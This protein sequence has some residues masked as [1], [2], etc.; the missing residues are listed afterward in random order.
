MTALEH[1]SRRAQDPKLLAKSDEWRTPPR[2]FAWANARYGPF[3]LDAAAA[4][5]NHQLP[6]Y[7]T[8]ERSGLK[9]GWHCRTWINCPYSRGFKEKFL[10]W[11]R[12]QLLSTLPFRLEVACFLLPHDTSDGYW[13][14]CVTAPAGRYLGSVEEDSEVGHVTR[15]HWSRLTVERV[16][17][18]GRLRYEHRDGSSSCRPGTARHSS[19]LV[20]LARPGILRPLG[21]Q[22]SAGRLS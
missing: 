8:K 19:A 18:F 2:L 17:I 15:T 20:V 14:R 10:A 11:G 7:F 9:S 16:E 4:K 3:T 12:K 22:T 21:P 13:R 6:Q 5:W 1:W